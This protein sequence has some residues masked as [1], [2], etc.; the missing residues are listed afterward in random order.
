[1]KKI[2]LVM[3]LLSAV[4]TTAFSAKPVKKV[5]EKVAVDSTAVIIEKAKAGDAAAQNTVG[6]WYYMGKDSIK[7]DYKQALQWWA[8]SAKQENVDA[9]GNMA[10][11]YQL[12]RGTQPDS[13]MAVQLYETAIKKGNKGIIPQH[14]TIVKNTGSVFSSLL[15]RDCYIKGLGVKKDSKKA[16]YFQEM[17]AKGGHVDSQFALGLYYLN[18]KQADKAV[19]WFKKSAAQGNVGAIYYYGYLLFNG[20]GIAQDKANGIKY[21]ALAS[22]K[23]FPTADYQLGVIYRDG[24]GVEKSAEKAFEYMKKAALKGN[25]DAKWNLSTMY[26]NGE[27]T[28]VDYY[29]AAQWLAE[30]ALS[31]HKNEA[32]ALLQEDN[33]GPFSLYLMG[34]R[35]FFIGK[36]YASAIEY[37][38]KV[39]KTKNIEGTTMLAMCYANKDYVKQNLKKAVKILTKASASS[40]VACY[41]LSSMYEK[42]E[43]VDKDDKKAVEL[44]ENAAN[45]GIAYAA[46]KLGDRYMIGDG[47]PKDF[48]KAAVLYLDAEA[49]NRLT[50]QSAKN[51][52]ECYQKKVSVLPDLKDAEKRISKLN[53]QKT[54]GNMISLLKFLEKGK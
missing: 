43:G 32:N 12:G 21:L 51:L 8:R 39:E 46:C 45:V 35:K 5:V 54:N 42:G 10:M 4:S 41:Y 28:A 9:I 27:G 17:A 25:A 36:D 24:N 52:A 34:L 7:Q 23:G 20:M 29:F 31:T 11:C 40:P 2:F 48:S 44:L 50:P 1:M 16:T 49:Q 30:V 6:V 19:E 14:E 13:A 26:L 38:K 53:R 15:L 22:K 3:M 47:V 18:N 33:E 37:F